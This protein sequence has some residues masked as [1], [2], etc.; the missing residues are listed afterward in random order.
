M[1]PFFKAGKTSSLGL[2]YRS[3]GSLCHTFNGNRNL[4]PINSEAQLPTIVVI[5]GVFVSL[6][7]WP[8][9]TWVKWGYKLFHP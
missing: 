9:N 1:R 7:K 3:L 5:N 6:H 4:P 8:E 2:S